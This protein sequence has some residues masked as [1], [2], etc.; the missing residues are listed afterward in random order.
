MI[1]CVISKYNNGKFWYVSLFTRN[2]VGK[3]SENPCEIL[4]T[5][6][7]IRLQRKISRHLVNEKFRKT[8]S[9]VSNGLGLVR[10]GQITYYHLLK[11]T[12]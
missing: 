10:C 3:K 7:F 11:L 2:I 1:T 5:A 8:Q 4:T 9:G 6:A 12:K